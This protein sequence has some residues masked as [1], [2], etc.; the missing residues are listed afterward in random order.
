MPKQS[1]TTVLRSAMMIASPEGTEDARAQIADAVQ[2]KV[3]AVT[4]LRLAL[5]QIPHLKPHALLIEHG[6]LS[7]GGMRAARELSELSSRRRV[8]VVVFGATEHWSVNERRECGVS[9]VVVGR[10]LRDMVDTLH[11]AIEHADEHQP[12]PAGA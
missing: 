2:L 5:A 7:C 9:H 1:T 6:A 4:G 12:A 8:P 10:R 3:R 11:F